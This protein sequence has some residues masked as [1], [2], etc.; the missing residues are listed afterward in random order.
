[1]S[2]ATVADTSAIGA[3]L[4]R[5]V[6]AANVEIRPTALVPYRT[7]DTVERGITMTRDVLAAIVNLAIR[8]PA[9]S[10]VTA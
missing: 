3:D 1:M 10:A 6:G 4:G 2:A 9:P 5:I 8:R 7:D